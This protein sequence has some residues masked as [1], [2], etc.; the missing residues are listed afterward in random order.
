MF[1]FLKKK[2]EK[3]KLQDRYKKLLK[4][5]HALSTIDRKQ[6]DQ[7]TWEADQ[8]LKQIESLSQ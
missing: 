5:A 3:E 2:S 4:E 1:G 7:K 8:V 6:S